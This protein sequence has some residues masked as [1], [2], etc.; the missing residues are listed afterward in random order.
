[1]DKNL[2]S[3]KSWTIVK[4]NKYVLFN[5]SEWE[6]RNPR[7]VLH[8]SRNY[9]HKILRKWKLDGLRLRGA[10]P[11]PAPGDHV[12][13]IC[14]AISH[15]SRH[16]TGTE[17]DQWGAVAV[18]YRSWWAGLPQPASFLRQIHIV[19]RPYDTSRWVVVS[20]LHLLQ[21]DLKHKLPLKLPME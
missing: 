2:E 3:R 21:C 8:C 5:L 17:P 9:L 6:L 12:T 20:H 4:L 11:S 13:A 10:G 14:N 15:W 1:M 7:W 16:G 19:F 18:K